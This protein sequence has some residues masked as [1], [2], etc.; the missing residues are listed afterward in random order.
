MADTLITPINDSFVDLDLIMSIAPSNGFK[1]VPSR[2]SEMVAAA[3]CGRQQVSGR[4]TDWVVTRNRTSP[5]GSR[6]EG[7]VGDLLEHAAANIGFRIV[8]GLTERVV[9]RELFPLGLTAFD[10]LDQKLLQVKPTLSH[11]LARREVSDLIASI[12]L[13]AKDRGTAVGA[14]SITV[15]DAD[16]RASDSFRTALQAIAAARSAAAHPDGLDDDLE[17]DPNAQN[18]LA[19]QNPN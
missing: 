3:T 7:E 6:N 19:G 14:T 1:P 12:G 9:F 2:Y 18:S 11:V 4:S 17:C 15:E 5:L 16:L 13:L 8:P 10:T